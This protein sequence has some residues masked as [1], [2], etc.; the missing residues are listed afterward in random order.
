MTCDRNLF[1]PKGEIQPELIVII[2]VG[3][4]R[5]DLPLASCLAVGVGDNL[6]QPA[7]DKC[8]DIG[9][10]ILQNLRSGVEVGGKLPR[11]VVHDGLTMSGARS[12]AP[13]AHAILYHVHYTDRSE[14]F[15]DA[16][17]PKSQKRLTL[18]VDLI[19]GHKWI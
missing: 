14:S 7:V 4:R 19:A 8:F 9:A 16:N 5:L 6:I 12:K 1:Q 15:Q 11:I 2:E 10:A 13:P 18:S 3:Q 17:N